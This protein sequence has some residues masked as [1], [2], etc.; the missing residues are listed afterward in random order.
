MTTQINIYDAKT[1]LSSLLDRALAGET[2]V[3]ARAG[4]PLVRLVPIKRAAKS[5]VTFGGALEGKIKL[6]PAF[7]DPISDAELLGEV[8][9]R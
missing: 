8:S 1:Q 5:G 2:I 6:K 9:R 4:E 7:S 3:I